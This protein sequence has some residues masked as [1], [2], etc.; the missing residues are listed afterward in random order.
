ARL[1][2]ITALLESPG[3]DTHG[4]PAYEG[5]FTPEFRSEIEE[6][7]KEL[8]DKIR[9]AEET[10]AAFRKTHPGIRA[11]L[12]GE[13]YQLQLQEAISKD[14]S[15]VTAQKT[16]NDL[17]AKINNLPAQMSAAS[18]VSSGWETARPHDLYLESEPES[19]LA[20]TKTE[21]RK[22]EEALAKAKTDAKSKAENLLA[23][24]F[25]TFGEE[26]RMQ[27]LETSVMR[28]FVSS[29]GRARLVQ[30]E[31]DRISDDDSLNNL[32]KADEISRITGQFGTPGVILAEAEAAIQTLIADAMT[33]RIGNETVLLSSAPATVLDILNTA[34]EDR[35]QLLANLS[36]LQKKAQSETLSQGSLKALQKKIAMIGRALHR[37][38]LLC[39]SLS[40]VYSNM[41]GLPVNERSTQREINEYQMMVDGIRYEGVLPS[42]T[43]QLALTLKD[44]R[45]MMDPKNTEVDENLSARLKNLDPDTRQTLI[46]RGEE[47]NTAQNALRKMADRSSRG[48]EEGKV[49]KLS[50][51]GL[52][53]KPSFFALR[54]RKIGRN[55]IPQIAGLLEAV[56]R[57]GIANASSALNRSQPGAEQ[58]S[59]QESVLPGAQ[60]IQTPA[61]RAPAVSEALASV[62]LMSQ[63]NQIVAKTDL[64]IKLLE[65]MRADLG[66]GNL[67]FAMIDERTL[68][69][70]L[71]RLFGFADTGSLEN[72]K[73]LAE[74]LKTSGS[75]CE[76]LGVRLEKILNDATTKD[77]YAQA[78]RDALSLLFGDQL[79]Q[80]SKSAQTWLA[81]QSKEKQDELA[82][83]G[84]ELQRQ[85]MISETS[86]FLARV[87]DAQSNGKDAIKKSV[88]LARQAKGNKSRTRSEIAAARRVEARGRI[89]ASSGI[90]L[91][92]FT[93][94]MMSPRMIPMLRRNGFE[95][96]ATAFE[97]KSYQLHLLEAKLAD[98]VT[99]EADSGIKDSALDKGTET[100]SELVRQLRESVARTTVD[101]QTADESETVRDARQS[102]EE[103]KRKE[104]S[105]KDEAFRNLRSAI[106]SAE[107]RENQLAYDKAQARLKA[108]Q[109]Q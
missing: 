4:D 78:K 72:L 15:V 71:N 62:T 7:K 69:S 48:T 8:P 47:A 68:I 102:L 45:S 90:V 97:E 94:L 34:R 107:V 30:E 5:A 64:L 21:M 87:R 52:G 80:S 98:E 60:E 23:R 81:R 77:K 22:A 84:A 96:L 41:S 101:Q 29:A 1:A 24:R 28:T 18:V 13:G 59:R 3:W 58:S 54:G 39:E 88:K 63:D 66:L 37:Q 86:P 92:T 106:G 79:I 74:K 76:E 89:Y 14:Q 82:E 33:V 70:A 99:N 100:Q 46:R 67:D 55:D 83:G 91:K 36:E 20:A 17:L 31:I 27:T 103:T 51:I 44:L 65:L 108:L 85:K 2:L 93:R 73:A 26:L 35:N 50:Q 38:Q 56:R 95:D 9:Q 53:D 109:A 12:L 61:D 6:L 43:S 19:E 16:C 42:D 49:H 32:E 57:G 10:I 104:G 25:M 75:G 105:K 11:K 40:R